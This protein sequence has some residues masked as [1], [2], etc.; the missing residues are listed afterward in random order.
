MNAHHTE[1]FL[2]RGAVVLGCHAFGKVVHQNLIDIA[3]FEP[4]TGGSFH[5][6]YA[7]VYV[8]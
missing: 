6:T 7:P 4:L 2:Q 3:Q 8:G 1:A 5:Y